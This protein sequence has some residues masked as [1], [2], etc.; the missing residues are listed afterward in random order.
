M[1][2]PV[3]HFEVVGKDQEKLSEF[4]G[5]LF[6]WQ[7]ESIPDMG[8]TMVKGEES[9]IGGGI[10]QSQDGGSGHV[11]FYVSADDPQAVLDRAG[12]LGG[13]TVMPVT[14]MPMVTFGL[15]ADPEGHVIGVVKSQPS[16]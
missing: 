14:E 8:Y 9:G 3:I 13:S 2:H 6:G 7:T 5:D 16:G 1:A 15:L 11:T 4:Y 12:E 10:G